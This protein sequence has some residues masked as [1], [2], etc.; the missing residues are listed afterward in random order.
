[1]QD[2]DEISKREWAATG[3]EFA[4]ISTV[5]AGLADKNEDVHTVPRQCEV[6]FL[7][8]GVPVSTRSRSCLS[9][10]EIQEKTCK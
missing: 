6:Q 9:S 7:E 3:N 1:M 10:D 4:V 8:V 2:W 5:P